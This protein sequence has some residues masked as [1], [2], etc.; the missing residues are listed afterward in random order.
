MKHNYEIVKV[1]LKEK[2][3]GHERNLYPNEYCPSLCS[4]W[5]SEK[6]PLIKI[7]G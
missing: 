1:P 6:L 7:F 2:K 4:P 5:V 3:K